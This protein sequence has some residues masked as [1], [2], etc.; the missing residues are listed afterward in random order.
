MKINKEGILFWCDSV[1]KQFQPRELENIPRGDNP[2]LIQEQ[3]LAY[4][5]RIL[6]ALCEEEKP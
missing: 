3:F 4:S 2:R 6:R 5:I 1:E